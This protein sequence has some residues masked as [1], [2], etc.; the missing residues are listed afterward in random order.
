MFVA[1]FFCLPD[2][3]FHDAPLATTVYDRNGEL[4]G[5]RIAADGQW[6]FPSG[7]QALPKCYTDAL[8]CFEDKRFRHHPGI[9][10][11][12]V[13][14]ALRDNLAKGRN[15]SGAS[16]ISMQVTRLLGSHPRTLG[17]KIIEAAQAL[18]LEAGW[19][20][21]EILEL[22]AAN[23]P[24]G[25]NVVGLEAA[26][27]RYFGRPP[28][29]ISQAEAALLAIL[30]NSPS[31]LH[32]GRGRD[33]L[34]EKR[35]R[36]LLRMLKEKLIDSA[37]CSL[38]LTEPLPEKPLPLP[39][40]AFHFVEKCAGEHPGQRTDSSLDLGLQLRVERECDSWSRELSK[41]GVA[42]LAAVIYDAKTCEPLAYIGNADLGRIREG[43]QVDIAS[44]P[45]STGSIL[46]P[47][48]YTA[49]LQEGSLLPEQLVRDTPLNLNG[50]MPENFDRRFSGAVRASEALCRSLNVPAVHELR[51]YGVQKFQNLL[52]S[53]GMT[54]L[55]RDASDY[56]LS[57]ILGGAEGRLTEISRIYA[58][59]AAVLGGEEVEKFPLD[60]RVAI[61]HCFNALTGLKRPEELEMRLVSGIRKLAWKTGTSYGSRDAWAIAACPGYVIGVWAGNADGHGA[62]GI[63]GA[64]T[65][66]PVLF[67][68]AELLPGTAWFSEPGSEEGC[69]CRLCPESGYLPGPWCSR[70]E[71][72][73]LLPRT[74]LYSEPCPYHGAQGFILPPA[75]EWFY[76]QRHPEYV[77]A[78]DQNRMM[79]FIYPEDGGRIHIPAGQDGIAVKLAHREAG[80]NTV[81]W[82]L[83]GSY[84]AST[85]LLHELQIAP[86]PGQ[87]VLTAVD[88]GGRSES[89]C[90]SVY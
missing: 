34:K 83:D 57:L 88:S 13:A 71:E 15:I 79:E 8:I 78:P 36:L 9:D 4:L 86:P 77:P 31:G 7:K 5:A 19:S 3:P 23:A 44:S 18:R 69:L 84:I 37:S 30:P 22:Y 25:G 74:A 75:M 17:Y 64:R 89:V 58:R 87:H 45:R 72:A 26:C 63:T 67:S 73:V 2:K 55:K 32:P 70:T 16:T 65:A 12:A 43:M 14:R 49:M 21:D 33:L 85:R 59:M 27:W 42:D 48:L 6:R 39:E 53:C 66:G 80:K 52:T 54:S 28:G 81:W 41:D 11:L 82:H 46:K 24:F 68:L 50:F 47:V 60:D 1:W 35:D 90:F 20:K 29:E 40:H 62:P 76:R 10:P 38:A 56:G 61:W 51:S